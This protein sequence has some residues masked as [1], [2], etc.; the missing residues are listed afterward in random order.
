MKN[1]VTIGN[2]K[3][4]AIFARTPEDHEA[5]LMRAP[6]P[7]PVMCFL[8]DKAGVRKFWMRDTPSPLDILF[9][10]NGRIIDILYGEP[11]SEELIGS[12]SPCDLVIEMP[13]GY[14]DKYGI[15]LKDSIKLHG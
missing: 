4:K 8:F 10:S 6:W 13:Y 7:P 15:S 2:N 3:F 9:C 5:G 14:V 12:N 1:S 11:M